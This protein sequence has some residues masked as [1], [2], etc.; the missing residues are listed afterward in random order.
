MFGVCRPAG[1]AT[2]RQR[3]LTGP[4]A[5]TNAIFPKILPLAHAPLHI[6]QGRLRDPRNKLCEKP[7]APRIPWLY[8]ARSA[9]CRQTLRPCPPSRKK[10]YADCHS[11]L[12]G[13]QSIFR[14]IMSPQRRGCV[15]S[16]VRKMRGNKVLKQRTTL[17]KYTFFLRVL[18][19]TGNSL[20]SSNIIATNCGGHPPWHQILSAPAPY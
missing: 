2:E 8:P 18:A 7:R 5:C 1:A 17:E 19:M 10:Q 4:G 14:N 3:A 16:S 13:C 15:P 11:A 20:L 9:S 6:L 12:A